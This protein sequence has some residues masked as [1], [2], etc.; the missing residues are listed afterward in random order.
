MLTMKPQ[1]AQAANPDQGYQLA[2]LHLLNG[3][4]K[5]AVTVLNGVKAFKMAQL[6]MTAVSNT[7]VQHQIKTMWAG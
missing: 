1:V 5:N 2:M 3:D 6:A 7:K 4:I